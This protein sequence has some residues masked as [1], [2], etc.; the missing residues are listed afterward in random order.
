M[1]RRSADTDVYTAIG[2]PVRR[3]ILD[4][5]SEGEAPVLRIAK[6][7]PGITG[8]A[9]SQHLKVLREVGLVVETRQGRLRVYRLNPVLLQQVWGW[10]SQYER[11]WQEK[12]GTL[13]EFLKKKRKRI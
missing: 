13:G 7:F 4:Y 1:S 6:L 10:V 5:L 8:P 3:S 9:L 12:L 2:H 11:F